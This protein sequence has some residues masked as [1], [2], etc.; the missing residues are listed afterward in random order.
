MFNCKQGTKKEEEVKRK[1]IPR[2]DNLFGINIHSNRKREK[3]MEEPNEISSLDYVVWV[4]MKVGND[5]H[6]LLVL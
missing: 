3:K 6:M 4:H 1:M 2:D 5:M